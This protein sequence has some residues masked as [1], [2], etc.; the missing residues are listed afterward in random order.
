MSSAHDGNQSRNNLRMNTGPL[1]FREKLLARV[2]SIRVHTG[3]SRKQLIT[4][5]LLLAVAGS[6]WA[7]PAGLLL[8]HRLRI[9]TGMPRMAVA[10]DEAETLAALTPDTPASLD[11][12]RTVQLDGALRRDPFVPTTNAVILVAQTIAGGQSSETPA[13]ASTIESPVVF[14][15]PQVR[16]SG[17]ARGL[18]T[19]ILDGIVRQVGERFDIG[20]AA[21]ELREVRFAAV[22]VDI[23]GAGPRLLL[24]SGQWRELEN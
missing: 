22:V 3:G 17:T 10:V 4:F 11:A 13:G 18:G 19:A 23:D 20:G 21:M 7:R 24:L 9:I 2:D 8:W 16:L 1:T 12:G 14:A 5:A 15:L 6:L